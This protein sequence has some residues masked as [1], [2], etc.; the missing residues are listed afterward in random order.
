M[1]FRNR[2]ILRRHENPLRGGLRSRIDR[3]QASACFKWLE[4][5][6]MLTS[7]SWIGGTTGYWDVAKN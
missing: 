1:M 6:Q 5:R 7:V 2:S 3:R 4:E